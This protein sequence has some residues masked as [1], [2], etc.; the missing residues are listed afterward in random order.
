MTKLSEMLSNVCLDGTGLDE[1]RRKTLVDQLTRVLA[2]VTRNDEQVTTKRLQERLRHTLRIEGAGPATVRNQVY[3]LG[4]LLDAARREGV[5]PVE[6]PAFDPGFPPLPLPAK[7]GPARRRHDALMRFRNWCAEALTSFDRVDGETF[8]RYRD[9]L[10]SPERRHGLRR[11][12]VLYSDLLA[13]WKEQAVAGRFR[14][15]ELPRWNDASSSRYGLPRGSWPTGV[16]AD[17]A[18]LERGARNLPRSGEKRRPVPLRDVSLNVYQE[19]LELLLG[20]AVHELRSD[21]SKACLAQLLGDERLVLGFV[22]WHRDCRCGG[23]EREYH[24]AWLFRYA[25]WLE[26]LGG[27]SATADRYRK[28]AG[29]LRTRQIRDPFPE[30]PI[31]YSEFVDA[32]V[33]ATSAAIRK[34][35]ALAPDGGPRERRSAA[36]A[37]RD[38]VCLA[39]LICRPMRSENIRNLNLGENLRRLPD[40]TWRI[41]FQS[42]EMKTRSYGCEFP[43]AVVEALELYL[44]RPRSV[45]LNDRSSSIVFPTVSGRALTAQDLWRRM[46]EIGLRHLSVRTNP[47]LFRYLVPCAY[48]LRHP[49]RLIEIQALLGHSN[50]AVTL[51][52][53]VRVYSQIASR[54][55]AEL[56]RANCPSLRRLGE[57]LPS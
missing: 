28:A 33:A 40:G 57:L 16:E 19:H 21:I 22:Q 2:N 8:R 11:A 29:S 3:R 32:A 6:D 12:E 9:F 53:Y 54:R 20:H 49:D 55:V 34:W 56:Q 17:F 7:P 39:L 35:Q 52:C 23:E 13:A 14:R 36:C 37:L 1:G 42:H 38:A 15:L 41:Q 31:D 27:S 45:L 50:L 46:T 25:E 24:R 5:L 10:R 44:G 30:R 47:H 43:R 18:R 26:W 48:L 51:K 4:L